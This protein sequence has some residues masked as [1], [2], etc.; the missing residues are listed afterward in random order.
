MH[1]H[2]I[3]C[4]AIGLTL[5]SSG[6]A[7]ALGQAAPAQPPAEEIEIPKKWFDDYEGYEEA[8]EL[9][10]Q[11]GADM[12]VYFFREAPSNEKGLYRW[13]DKKALSEREVKDLF[14]HY[15][16]V[17][18]DVTDD[19]DEELNGLIAEYGVKKTLAMY[20]RRPNGFHR[21]YSPF[22]W[23]SGKPVLRDTDEL[24]EGIIAGSSPEYAQYKDE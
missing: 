22:N 8:L 21:R 12:I 23:S 6:L 20:I 3:L 14:R 10:E 1:A 7:P 16:R 2:P 4:F 17:R 9:Q 5:F 18:L 13:F 19:D 15:I 24:V 11:T